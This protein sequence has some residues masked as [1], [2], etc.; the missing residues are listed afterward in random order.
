MSISS[1]YISDFLRQNGTISLEKIGTLTL[2]ENPQ[3]DEDG[4][5]LTTAAF[6]Y[7]KKA[8]T[9]P[10]FVDYL[11][12][13]LQKPLLLVQSDLE[14]FLDQSRQLMN[15]GSKPLE[16]DGI[17]FIHAENNGVY[18]FSTK[19]PDGFK[20]T[21]F[22][23]K[24]EDAHQSRSPM[25]SS[26]NYASKRQGSRNLG[27][28]I[29]ALLLIAIIALGF[30]YVKSKPDFFSDNQ[31]KKDSTKNEK[32]VEKKEMSLPPVNA[33]KPKRGGYKF[34]IQ[35]FDNLERSN[36]RVNQL[37]NYGNTVSTDSVLLNGKMTYRLYVTDENATPMDTLRIK[38]SLHSYFGHTITVE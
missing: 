9:T 28:W 7:D 20:E 22:H 11:A 32:L 6:V 17:G 12:A 26:V 21:A 15:I 27:R 13:V 8:E 5:L 29:L 18:S 38:D 2:S 14:Y 24:Y 35:T 1:Q 10:D 34:I 33:N 36:K 31:Q 19:A 23:K 3:T 30:Y 25:L 16:L 37:K 4:A